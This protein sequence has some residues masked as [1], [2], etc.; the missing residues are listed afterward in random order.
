[1]EVGTFGL[2]PNHRAEAGERGSRPRRR[3]SQSRRFGHPAAIHSRISA[4][5]HRLEP[6]ILIG[7]GMR[8]ALS[9]RKTDLSDREISLATPL[10]SVMSGMR[11]GVPCGSAFMVVMASHLWSLDDEAC[12]R[13]PTRFTTGGWVAWLEWAGIGRRHI[14]RQQPI[15]L[16]PADS[17]TEWQ[18]AAP[19]M[20]RN[21]SMQ[22]AAQQSLGRRASCTG[23]HALLEQRLRLRSSRLSLIAIRGSGEAQPR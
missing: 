21:S 5:R 8:P 1:M 16:V 3:D 6:P 4:M 15:E 23:R 20:G 14:R 10:T 7:L 22:V 17:G 2:G 18:S 13:L 12:L 11:S 19:D 9:S